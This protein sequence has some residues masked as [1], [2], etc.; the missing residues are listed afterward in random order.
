MLRVQRPPFSHHPFTHEI[1]TLTPWPRCASNSSF[2][3]S[4]SDTIRKCKRARGT[5][6]ADDVVFMLISDDSAHNY[7]FIRL[8]TWVKIL[9][10]GC[11]TMGCAGVILQLSVLSFAALHPPLTFGLVSLLQVGPKPQDSLAF[12]TSSSRAENMSFLWRLSVFGLPVSSLN[13]CFCWTSPKLSRSRGEI[14][15]VQRAAPV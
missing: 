14:T 8:E 5:I 2:L 9:P 7:W 4:V 6:E 10:S 1:H 15:L 3:S 11:M 13:F 12:P